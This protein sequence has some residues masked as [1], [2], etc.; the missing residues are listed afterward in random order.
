MMSAASLHRLKSLLDRTLI[1]GD[2]EA[3]SLAVV[4]DELPTADFELHKIRFRME[5]FGMYRASPLYMFLQAYP[6]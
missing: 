4:C 6:E 1:E 3:Y 5:S 2:G